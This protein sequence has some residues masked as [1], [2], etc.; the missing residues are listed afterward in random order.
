MSFKISWKIIFVA[1]LF[2]PA[3][4]FAQVTNYSISLKQSPTEP[5]PGENVVFTVSA[6]EFNVDLSNISWKIDG[7]VVSSGQ[8]IKTFSTAAPENGKTKT[9]GVTVIPTG[10]LP[11]NKGVT[12]ASAEMDMLWQSL[13]GYT[14]PFYRGRTLPVSQ[15]QVK[16]VAIPV[17]KNA[18]GTFAKPSDF[19]YSWRRDSKNAPASSGIGKNSLGFAN[20]TLE[21]TNRVD[22]SATNGVRVITGA[23]ILKY[24]NPEIIFYKN[25]LATGTQY[26]KALVSGY[27]LP[28]T[29]SLHLVAEP[30]FLPADFKTNG[31][32]SMQWKLNDQ[33]VNSSNE[34]GHI[35]INSAGLDSLAVG[36]TYDDSTRYF[37]TFDQRLNLSFK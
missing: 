9:V 14:P 22:V 28:K 27:T 30:F 25:D 20:Q 4:S 11:I 26:N 3:I 17:V 19:V 10:G 15:S 18:N 7:K 8:G 6:F 1:L 5:K 36:F 16:V 29:Q 12:L 31:N 35:I 34:K 13:D 32:V 21:T 23:V 37:R 24:L 2:I 33:S